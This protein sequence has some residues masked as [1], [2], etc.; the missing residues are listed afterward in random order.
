MS[1]KTLA[2]WLGGVLGTAAVLLGLQRW[3]GPAPSTALPPAPAASS[4]LTA[5][6][7]SGVLAGQTQAAMPQPTWRVLGF[8]GTQ[9]GLA[10]Q[11]AVLVQQDSQRPVVLTVGQP[12][13]AGMRL[14]DVSATDVVIQDSD[15]RQHRL[16][17]PA[18]PAA[19]DGIS[20]TSR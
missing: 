8:I 13:E 15:G 19:A 14:L 2:P 6:G 16:P 10:G 17:L 11:T 18:A 12:N 7:A 5:Q 1:V 4:T 9:T 20:P 3:L